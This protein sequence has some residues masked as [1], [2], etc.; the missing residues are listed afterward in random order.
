MEFE[1][2]EAATAA[3]AAIDGVEIGPAVGS[4][5]TAAYTKAPV[6][7]TD[8]ETDP[9]W[10]D[11]RELP[12]KYSLRACWSIPLISSEGR[13]LGTFAMYYRETRSPAADELGLIDAAG[14]LAT[15]AIERTNAREMAIRCH[16]G[17]RTATRGSMEVG[18]VSVR[19]P[20]AGKR[21]SGLADGDV[22]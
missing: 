13:V 14:R 8:I 7:V 16:C 22:H 3:L 12:L 4:C 2:V 1:S 18:E 15:I 17:V 20:R 19:V 5:G 10:S 11:Y 21:A 9:L 6:I